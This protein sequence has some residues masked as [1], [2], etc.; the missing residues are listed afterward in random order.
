MALEYF[1]ICLICIIC[2]AIAALICAIVIRCI[3]KTRKPKENNRKR[4]ISHFHNER[5]VSQ[6]PENEQNN[7][8]CGFNAKNEI[9]WKLNC[10]G[11]VCSQC[12]AKFFTCNV[13]SQMF[14]CPMCLGRVNQYSLF[15]KGQEDTSHGSSCIYS[16]DSDDSCRICFDKP[17]YRRIDCQST[18]RHTLCEACYRRLV[19]VD[20]IKK[21]PF[22]KTIINK[23]IIKEEQAP[24]ILSIQ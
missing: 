6:Q 22:C 19:L 7:I 13:S 20:K 4:K 18:V 8:K 24:V 1:L 12:I 21:C 5:S 2:I 16:L 11:L 15:I 3:I 10:G 23:N 9:M 14:Y 17:A